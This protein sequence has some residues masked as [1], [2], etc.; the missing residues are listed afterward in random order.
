MGETNK[1]KKKTYIEKEFSWSVPASVH[2]ERYFSCRRRHRSRSNAC[3]VLELPGPVQQRG[4]GWI[5]GRVPRL[6][7]IQHFV[8][9]RAVLDL[10]LVNELD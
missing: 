4:S 6:Q 9:L 3:Q 10:V 7:L 8:D 5:L 1:E 2:E